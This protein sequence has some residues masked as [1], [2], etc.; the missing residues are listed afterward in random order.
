[1]GYGGWVST[2]EGGHRRVRRLCKC[3]GELGSELRGGAR[4][5]Q[6][7]VKDRVVTRVEGSNT[8]PEATKTGGSAGTGRAVFPRGEE[9]CQA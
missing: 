3:P 7:N 6:K 8:V 9:L 5:R 4:R 2:G 1:M